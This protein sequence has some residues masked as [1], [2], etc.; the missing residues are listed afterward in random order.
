MFETDQLP[1]VRSLVEALRE[2][3]S[4]VGTGVVVIGGLFQRG[5]DLLWVEWLAGEPCTPPTLEE[6]AAFDRRC[7]LVARQLQ[8]NRAA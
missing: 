2:R 4:V 5:D 3:A 8:K 7:A 1:G 6:V